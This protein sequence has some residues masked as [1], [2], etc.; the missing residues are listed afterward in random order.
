MKKKM[1]LICIP[2]FLGCSNESIEKT[3]TYRYDGVLSLEKAIDIAKNRNL[4]LKIKKLEK[5]ISTLDKNISFGTFLPAINLGVGQTLLNDDIAIEMEVPMIGKIEPSFI[6]KEFSNF[7][8][9]ATIPIFVPS[10]WYIYSAKKNREDM[11]EKIVDF[12]G[13]LIE[14]NTINQFYQVLSL[15]SQ[16]EFIDKEI[17]MT[18]ALEK[19]AKISL[20]IEGI[21]PWEY[22]K[23]LAYQKNKKVLKNINEREL[24]IAKMKLL[25]VLNVDVFS[26]VTLLEEEISLK[27]R[28]SLEECILISLKS[29]DNIKISEIKTEIDSNLIKI[30]ITNFLPK[31]VLGGGYINDSNHILAD[32]DFLYGNVSGILSIFNGFKNINEYKKVV[33]NKKIGDL[34]LEKEI[35][36][37]IIETTKAYK[38]L[39][40]IEEI[41]DTY[42]LK[43]KSEDGRLKQ[44]KIEYELGEIGEVEFLEAVSERE[45]ASSRL[46]K[47]KYEYRVSRAV[48]FVAMGLNPSRTMGGKI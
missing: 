17:Q 34:K 9:G 22:E 14:L 20:E 11:S 38:K 36:K 5:E 3:T 45:K 2:I 32:P 4:D 42:T 31:I 27:Q 46:V 7:T 12:S 19:R 33:K 6:D 44:K 24:E 43:L 30:A 13:K 16:K 39:E 15:E 8:I 18:N 48:L 29:N 1:L 10:L 47:A 41:V 28:Y 23:V 21:L 25:E 26:Q 37:T 40:T 35:V